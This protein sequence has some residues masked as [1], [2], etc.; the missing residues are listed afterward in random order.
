LIIVVVTCVVGILVGLVTV[1]VCCIQHK[2]IENK[3]ISDRMQKTL[4]Q[5]R[6]FEK[7]NRTLPYNQQ[8]YV[9]L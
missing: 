6:E 8:P 2:K 9:T 1:I 7:K 5:D 4:Q 3:I